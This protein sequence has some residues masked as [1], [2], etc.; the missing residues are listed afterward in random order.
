MH[1]LVRDYCLIFNDNMAVHYVLYTLNCLFP[2]S[3]TSF[4]VSDFSEEV[5]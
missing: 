2:Y 4:G 3:L 5:S 1:I